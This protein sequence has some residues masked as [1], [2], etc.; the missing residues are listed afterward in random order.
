MLTSEDGGSGGRPIKSSLVVEEPDI[1]I[2]T[3]VFSKA[4]SR[5]MQTDKSGNYGPHSTRKLFLAGVAKYIFIRVQGHTDGQVVQPKNA[6]QW[7]P[8][9]VGNGG[10][11]VSAVPAAAATAPR[12]S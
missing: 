8:L 3:V 6:L 9:G 1:E 5:R 4:T 7:K 10:L 12:K 11:A 2:G